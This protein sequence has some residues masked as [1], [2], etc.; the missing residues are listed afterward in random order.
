MVKCFWYLFWMFFW[1]LTFFLGPSKVAKCFWYLFWIFFWALIFFLGTNAFF[2]IFS[3]AILIKFLFCKPN[4]KHFKVVSY[5]RV[6]CK[7]SFK[8]NTWTW[9]KVLIYAK[10]VHCG[11]RHEKIVTQYRAM[12]V[13][14]CKIVEGKFLP[15][16]NKKRKR[17]SKTVA[18]SRFDHESVG[19]GDMFQPVLCSVCDTEVAVIDKDEVY[20]FHNVLPSFV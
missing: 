11:H 1:S 19:D 18:Q 5:W 8:K 7:C 16:T 9:K 2:D 20:H 12:F 13:L 17:K 6:P 15:L 4:C 14:N 3:F 10:S